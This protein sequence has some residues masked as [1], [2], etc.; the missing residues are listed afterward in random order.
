[1]SEIPE[2]TQAL[3]DAGSDP[4][5]REDDGRTP[6]HN[7]ARKSSKTAGVVSTPLDAGSDPNARD[8]DGQTPLHF[9]EM[10]SGQNPGIPAQRGGGG[11]EA[12]V[13]APE[14]APP[15]GIEGVE[16]LAR[17]NVTHWV[18]WLRTLKGS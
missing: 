8:E 16:P 7:A 15:Q 14:R 9:A 1:M 3:L 13:A 11:A 10:R 18:S 5:A 4:N 12:N 6:L 17:P 2:I